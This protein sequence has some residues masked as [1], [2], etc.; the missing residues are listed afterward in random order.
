ME[1]TYFVN[2]KLYNDTNKGWAYK[3]EL[4]TTDYNTAVRKFGELVSQYYGKDPYVFG[5]ISLTDMYEHVLDVKTWEPLPEPS[6]E[7]EV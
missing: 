6:P 1:L 3:T 7:P 4:K 5:T 2:Y